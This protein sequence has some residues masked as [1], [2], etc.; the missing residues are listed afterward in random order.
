[1]TRPGNVVLAFVAAAVMAVAF[2]GCSSPTASGADSGA[3]EQSQVVV[4]IPDPGNAG[5]LAAGK[6]DG[7]FEKA[8]AEVGARVQW[9]GLSGPF[10]PAALALN[11]GELD[12]SSGSI[13]SAVMALGQSPKFRLFARAEPDG[14]GEGILVKDDSGIESVSDLKGKKVAVWHGSTSEY[15]LL[16]ALEKEGLSPDDV[17]RVYLQPAK[18][19]AVFHSGQVD[20]WATWSTF[21]IPERATQPVHFLV[22]G[23]EV[24]SQNSV[25]WAVRTEFADQHPEIVK[26]VYEWIHNADL[27]RQQ[28]PEKYVNVFR[29]SG[30]DAYTADAKD[31]AVEESR[32]GHEIIPID[33]KALETFDEVANFYADRGITDGV[34]PVGDYVIDVT[35]IGT[36]DE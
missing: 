28:N 31:I 9:T 35:K 22:N 5:S 34:V 2:A 21:S 27:D 15:L 19:A 14:L 3:S 33:A 6:K 36:G 26:A 32:A 12:M 7:S 20:A 8:L 1:M 16:K 24:A 17:E 4:K 25:I 10:A 29:T 23:E 18:S 13:T 30:P 11:A